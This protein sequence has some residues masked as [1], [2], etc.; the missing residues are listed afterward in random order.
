MPGTR[1]QN[2]QTLAPIPLRLSDTDSQPASRKRSVLQ[3]CRIRRKACGG[4]LWRLQH[5]FCKSSSSFVV[6]EVLA[7]GSVADA[8]GQAC[9][10]CSA[11]CLRCP[12][13]E[14]FFLAIPWSGA[15][16]HWKRVSSGKGRSISLRLAL[17]L[18]L[19]SSRE[20]GSGMSFPCFA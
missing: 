6:L 10:F 15:T 3:A 17:I 20:Q 11:V 9:R 5:V 7:G 1:I 2:S 18:S 14:M 8:P 4:G 12:G 16:M 13:L 19:A